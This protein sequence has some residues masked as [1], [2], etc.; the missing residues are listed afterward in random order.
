MTTTILGKP[1]THKLFAAQV[2]RELEDE[3]R[4]QMKGK[5]LTMID[6]P[7]EY[8]TQKIIEYNRLNRWIYEKDEMDQERFLPILKRIKSEA[9]GEMVDRKSANESQVR[10]LGLTEE[11][12][13][14]EIEFK[15]LLSDWVELE[16]DESLP[17]R[18]GLRDAAIGGERMNYSKLNTLEDKLKSIRNQEKHLL[19]IKFNMMP[20]REK[21]DKYG[22]VIEYP[23]EG[24]RCQDISEELKD[25]I[26][27]RIQ[28]K[29]EIN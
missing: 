4:E 8:V 23:P 11:D 15:Q 12:I 13:L 10:Q 24:N 22:H 20:E 9:I 3:A 21:Y 17:A 14:F 28:I 5:M 7:N 2:I 6:E 27:N 19:E 16:L 26:T 25:V 18:Q 1:L 29:R